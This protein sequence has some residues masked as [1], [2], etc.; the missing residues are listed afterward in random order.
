LILSK[1]FA[2]KR[3]WSK[4]KGATNQHSQSSRTGLDKELLT[5]DGPVILDS[6]V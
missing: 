6:D 1:V 3:V 5:K 4:D 2:D